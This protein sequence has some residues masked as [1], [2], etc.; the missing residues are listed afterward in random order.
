MVQYGS[1]RE[2][3][4]ERGNNNSR[5]QYMS[6]FLSPTSRRRSKRPRSPPGTPGPHTSDDRATHRQRAY[7]PAS[8]QS[9]SKLRNF[10]SELFKMPELRTGALSSTLRAAWT[11]FVRPESTPLLHRK[12]THA[13]TVPTT[14][15][16]LNMPLPGAVQHLGDRTPGLG[17][18]L[19]PAYA[20]RGEN[21]G[22]PEPTGSRRR[23]GPG[24]QLRRA[25]FPT[26]GDLPTHSNWSGP[27]NRRRAVC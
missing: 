1:H 23:G 18:R 26:R 21:G 9:T 19:D 7:L 5:V 3:F 16:N 14:R 17:G 6:G 20:D 12:T 10:R 4:V 22:A 13:R 15:Q 2:G 27:A 24:I 8:P 11:S 25:P